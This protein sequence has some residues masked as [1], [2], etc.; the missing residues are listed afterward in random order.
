M[1]RRTFLKASA[2]VAAAGLALPLSTMHLQAKES[3]KPAHFSI[4][5]VKLNNGVNMPMLGFGTLDQK[6]DAGVE[7]ISAAISLGYRLLDTATIYGNEEFVGQAI[8]KN[9]IDRKKLFLT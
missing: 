7:S 4:P 9:G 3:E 1:N 6:G 2:S 8:K 5:D